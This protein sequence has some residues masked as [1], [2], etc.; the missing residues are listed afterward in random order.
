MSEKNTSGRGR[1]RNFATVI[2]LDSAPENWYDILVELKVPAFVSPYHDKDKN[3]T[4]EDKKPHFHVMLMFEGVKTKEQAEE[5]FNKIGGVGCEIVNS[6]RGYARY[7]CHLDNP[8]KTQYNTEEVRSL[9]G[10]DYISCIGLAIDKYTA[11]RELM[12]FVANNCIYSYAELLEYCATHR[13]DWFSCLCDNGTYVL[14]EYIK[15]RYWKDSCDG[16]KEVEYDG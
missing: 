15:S 6:L 4:G 3:P 7:L 12:D 11:I 10:A 13:Q 1:T 2:Y 8:E 9:C 14:K 5:M 16:L